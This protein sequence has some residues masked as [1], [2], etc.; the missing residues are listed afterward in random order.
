MLNKH[1]ISDVFLKINKLW[2]I[3]HTCKYWSCLLNIIN[4]IIKFFFN[5]IFTYIYRAG[6]KTAAP[7]RPP[8]KRRRENVPYPK[9]YL[10]FKKSKVF[11]FYYF[12][13]NCF[14]SVFTSFYRKYTIIL[15]KI[16]INKS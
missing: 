12:V 3:Q 8:P 11:S 4:Q 7:K 15:I 13:L 14:S 16:I 6:A 10:V 1:E 2:T 5:F 9:K